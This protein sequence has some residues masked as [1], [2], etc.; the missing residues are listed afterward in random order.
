[1]SLATKPAPLARS[2][3]ATLVLTIGA[4]GPV[5]VAAASTK[6]MMPR[7]SAQAMAKME[8]ASAAAQKAVPKAVSTIVIKNFSFS[9]GAITVKPGQKVKV[10]NR[11][12]VTHTVTSLT[13]K[14]NTGNVTPGKTVVFTAPKRPGTYPY[15]CNIHQYMTGKL[16]VSQSPK[17]HDSNHKKA[18]H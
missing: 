6:P 3:A 12:A 9:P 1:M 18:H 13:G 2:A 14:F 8:S 4:L 17:P 15:R 7:M 10:T 11:D 5:G 16:V